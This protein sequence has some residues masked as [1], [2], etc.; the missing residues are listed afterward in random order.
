MTTAVAYPPQLATLASISVDNDMSSKTD[1]STASTSTSIPTNST[2]VTSS[3][4]AVETSSQKKAPEG[5]LSPTSAKNGPPPKIVVKKEP[6]SSPDIA[7]SRHR[8]RKL[9]LSTNIPSAQSAMSARPSAGPLTAR[10]SAGLA[11]QDVGLACLSPGFQTHDPTMRE[12]L[13]RSISVRDQQ[14]HIIESRLQRTAKPNE[15]IDGSKVGDSQAFGPPIKTPTTRRRAPPGLSIVPPSHEQFANERVIQSAPLNQTFTGRHQPHP[16]T[17]HVANQSSN[18]SHTSHIHHVPATQT[19]NRLPPISDV[20]AAEGLGGP[21]DSTS[22]NG[23]YLPNSSSNSSHSNVRPAFPS[24][25]HHGSQSQAPSSDR[26]REYRS[27]EE[28]VASLSGG[29]EDL[30]PRI[31]HYGGH[32][33]PTPPSPVN[34]AGVSVLKAAQTTADG[35]SSRTGSGRRRMRAEYEK[36]MGSPPLGTGPEPRPGPFGEERDSPD[37]QRRKKEEFLS[38]CARAWDLFHS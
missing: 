31:V 1:A 36:D 16:L 13:Q 24:P 10:D 17:R 22:R 18:L 35:E 23:F 8:P 9:D 25:G 12:Q 20:F 4:A 7:H 37:T 11:M 34:G 2:P 32:Q 19:N 14:R 3:T 15:M 28:A 33:P 29:R 21:R 5:K 38:L 26:P 27:A 30:L 6:P